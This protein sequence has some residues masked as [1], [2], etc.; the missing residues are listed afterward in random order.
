MAS[1]EH[2]PTTAEPSATATGGS[3]SHTTA[4]PAHNPWGK[5][6]AA[7]PQQQ[8]QPQQRAKKSEKGRREEHQPSLA[9]IMNEEKTRKHQE[10][11]DRALA[12]ALS[13]ALNSGPPPQST[14]G[15]AHKKRSKGGRKTPEH[16]ASN[17]PTRDHPTS[18]APATVNTQ[19]SSVAHEPVAVPKADPTTKEPAVV[20]KVSDEDLARKLS[21]QEDYLYALRLQESLDNPPADSEV[22]Q[23]NE[24]VVT[25][26]KTRETPSHHARAA[27]PLKHEASDSEDSDDG[28]T[29]VQKPGKK[30]LATK[31][32]PVLCGKKN[33]KRLQEVLDGDMRNLSIDNPTFNLLVKHAKREESRRIRVKGKEDTT[34]SEQVLDTQTRL[35]ILKLINKDLISDISGVL[36]TGK[37]ASVYH[38]KRGSYTDANSPPQSCTE[39]AIKVF[40]TI[41]EYKHR[42]VY[43][44]GQFLQQFIAS[45]RK[46]KKC[47]K[48]WAQKELQNLRRIHRAGLPCPQPVGLF[49]HV[50]VMQFIGANGYPAPTLNDAD[51]PP[52]SLGTLYLQCADLMRKLFQ[53]CN[54]VHADF[55]PFNILYYEDQMYVIDVAQAVLNDHRNAMDFL[56]RDCENITRF[57]KGRGVPNV[58]SV[59]RLFDFICNPSIPEELVSEKL[60]ELTSTPD[61]TPSEVDDAVFLRSYM[62]RSLADVKDPAQAI[63]GVQQ[64]DP[65]SISH[66]TVSGITPGMVLGIDEEDDEEDE[67]EEEEEDEAEGG[68]SIFVKE[69][70]QHS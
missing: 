52:E 41:N 20:D 65:D 61:T 31:H 53:K 28:F 55:S 9:H 64:G 37:E 27:P 47:L 66:L 22:S 21:E 49:S 13:E 26:H 51:I 39:Y 30:S 25:V 59:H 57:F 70:T 4:P 36:S 50:L 24:T 68:E 7:A 29:V 2:V 63:E 60:Q 18:D 43:L 54:L 62:P 40:R 17:T 69:N 16:V 5:S 34:T 23:R 19:P 3:A 46:P 44:D 38:A 6:T 1:T 58:A 8:P 45:K 32:D 12:V 56:R 42:D 14:P 11:T 48:L 10:D 15:G 33:A 67:D 35:I